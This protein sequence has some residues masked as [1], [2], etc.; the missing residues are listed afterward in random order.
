MSCHIVW[1]WRMGAGLVACIMESANSSFLYG[2]FCVACW[3]SFD[4]LRQSWVLPYSYIWVVVGVFVVV[5]CCLG[6]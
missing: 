2:R 5:F 6:L 1:V 4:S 3:M